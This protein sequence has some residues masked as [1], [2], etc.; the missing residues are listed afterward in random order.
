MMPDVIKSALDPHSRCAACSHWFSD[1]DILT[2]RCKSCDRF[3][4]PHTFTPRR[5]AGGAYTPDAERAAYERALR[6]E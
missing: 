1:H 3:A 2:E 6:G 4:E 5:L